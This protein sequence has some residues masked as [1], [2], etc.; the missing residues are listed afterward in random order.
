[1]IE[2]L[3]RRQPRRRG[4]RVLRRLRAKTGY[5]LAESLLALLIVLLLST[6]I[7]TGVAF[8]VR[9]Y[10]AAMVRSETM[11][12]SSTLSSII[13]SDLCIIDAGKDRVSVVVDGE[14]NQWLS[15]YNSRNYASDV[16]PD[17]NNLSCFTIPAEGAATYRGNTYGVLAIRPVGGTAEQENLLLSRAAYSSYGLKARVAVQVDSEPD[18][19]EEIVKSFHV[20]L[21]I[22]TPDKK[23][24]PTS[25]EVLPLNR[26]GVT[27]A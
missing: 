22:L 16:N 2:L 4:T 6:G 9:Q 21:V 1:M 10:N 25:F 3:R 19:G 17:T 14:G 18:A 27:T 20:T 8:A 15:G 24:V 12:L 7:A 13:R 5:S 11:V 26:I 23:E